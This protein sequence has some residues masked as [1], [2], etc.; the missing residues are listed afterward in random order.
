MGERELKLPKIKPHSYSAIT[1]RHQR[2][3]V[4]L[5]ILSMIQTTSTIWTS[6]IMD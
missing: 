5:N 4:P 3:A 1:E 6:Q 2:M